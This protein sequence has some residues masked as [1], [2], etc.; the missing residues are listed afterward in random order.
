[1]IKLM[2]AIRRRWDWAFE[3]FKNYYEMKH[4]PL[5]KSLFPQV[6][7][8]K[9]NYVLRNTMFGVAD[10]QHDRFDYDVLTEMGFEDQAA[11]DAFLAAAALPE[12]SARMA[13]D[14]ENF[15]DRKSIVLFRVEERT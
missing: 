9:R 15:M 11:Y 5:A 1:M 8:Y 10:I 14:E 6:S 2:I 13:A 3:D 12:N 4:A 7:Y